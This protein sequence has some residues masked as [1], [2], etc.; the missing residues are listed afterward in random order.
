[1]LLPSTWAR[2]RR[3]APVDGSDGLDE[4]DGLFD[5]EDGEGMVGFDVDAQRREALERRRSGAC[6][7][8]VRLS[9]DLEEGFRD[10]SDDD[11]DEQ[12][13]DRGGFGRQVPGR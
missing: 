2:A 8:G 11:E 12:L 13:Q 5:D 6:D 1:M 7:G 3:S 9:R 4:D 10:D